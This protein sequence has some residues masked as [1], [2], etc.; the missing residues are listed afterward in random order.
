MRSRLDS[1][2][3]ACAVTS[4][5]ASCASTPPTLDERYEQ[6]SPPGRQ[7]FLAYYPLLRPPEKA[8]EGPLLLADNWRY[9]APEI[10]QH[11]DHH[12]EF[13]ENPS[14]YT[15]AGVKI[16]PSR[17]GPLVSGAQVDLQAEL[18]YADGR[19]ANATHDVHWS[20]QP[21]LARIERTSL[22]FECVHS[23]VTVSADFLGERT[24][25]RVIEI[26]KPLASLELSI[27]EG[28]R[29]LEQ[30]D[31]VKLRLHALCADGTRSE[32][33]C[34]ADWSARSR[35]VE[36]RGCGNIRLSPAHAGSSFSVSASYGGLRISRSFHTPMRR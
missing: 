21:A 27:D 20:V 35:G 3:S 33:S 5:L 32:V 9:E 23:D 4:L 36:A 15:L 26:R 11:I 29:S 24:G 7:V 10:R 34:Q 1:I 28:S 14:T 8:G 13:T 31:S 6:M 16:L 19:R 12:P 18:L 22:R 2:A 25:S 30:T 17:P